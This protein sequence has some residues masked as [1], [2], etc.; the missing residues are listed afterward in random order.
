MKHLERYGTDTGKSLALG[1][2]EPGLT[3][4]S[5]LLCYPELVNET[6]RALLSSFV[7]TIGG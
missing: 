3:P 4:A 1:L 5:V 2:E 7:K 6:S